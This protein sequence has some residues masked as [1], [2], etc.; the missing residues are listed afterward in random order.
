PKY[1]AP[2][3]G[4]FKSG[5]WT[6]VYA[7]F[8]QTPDGP[9]VLPAGKEKFIKYKI[10]CTVTDAE[11]TQ[12]LYAS[13]VELSLVSDKTTVLTYAQP[14]TWTTDPALVLLPREPG[15]GPKYELPTRPA[16][17]TSAKTVPMGGALY[18]TVGT[19]LAGFE[20]A[21]TALSGATFDKARTAAYETAVE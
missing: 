19:K 10:T 9:L 3:E 5:L 18:L 12:A 1:D 17:I 16:L 11:G 2:S 21:I 6:P 14:G 7:T 15:G 20:K 13:D 4:A 8:A